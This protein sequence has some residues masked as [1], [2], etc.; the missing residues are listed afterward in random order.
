M[1][2]KKKSLVAIEKLGRI[3]RVGLYAGKFWECSGKVPENF[4]VPCGVFFVCF[5]LF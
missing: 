3:G 4:P 2:K 1:I 5:I